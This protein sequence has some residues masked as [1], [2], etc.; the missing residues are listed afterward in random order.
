MKTSFERF[1]NKV[2]KNGK[3]G[4]WEWMASCINSGYGQIRVDGKGVLAHR[5]SYDHFIGPIPDGHYVCHHCDNPSCVN[6]EHLFLGTQSDNMMDRDNKGRHPSVT[7][8]ERVARGQHHGSKTCP[9]RIV[10]GER[11]GNAL[12]TSDIVRKAREEYARKGITYKQ[13]AK[14]YGVSTMG[15]YKAIQGETWK[16]L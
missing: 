12:L 9:E 11:H 5:F 10:R 13:L 14:K 7:H 3:D 6:P 1:I 15:I 2:N 16:H 4:C 8:P